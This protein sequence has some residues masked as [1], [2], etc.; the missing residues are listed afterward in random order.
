[1][2]PRLTPDPKK[3]RP[4]LSVLDQPSGPKL[5]VWLTSLNIPK[6]WNFPALN[7][8]CLFLR[9]AHKGPRRTKESGG[10]RDASKNSQV[11]PTLTRL[12][13]PEP[14]GSDP[15]LIVCR[16]YEQLEEVR[17]LQ[18]V[19]SRQQACSQNRLKA[20]EFHQ[21]RFWSRF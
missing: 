5:P 6:F 15:Q 10:G 13:G 18:A 3:S 9:G 2:E 11:L 12:H 7:G 20:Q 16:L 21:V 14:A 17:E 4:E 8:F 19:R 1:M